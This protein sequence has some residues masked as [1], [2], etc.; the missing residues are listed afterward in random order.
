[1]SCDA[2]RTLPPVISQGYT[3]KGTYKEVAGLNTC[4][5][6]T[7]AQEQ[8]QAL[9]FS[10]CYWSAKCFHWACGPLRHFRHGHPD[11]AGGRPS[12]YKIELIGSG[13]RFLRRE[14]CPARMVPGGHR[15]EEKRSYELRL[16]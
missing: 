13:A 14:L 1:M 4:K 11:P 6:H 7:D 9:T 3:T 5:S 16:Q 12:S 2:C 10:R 15:R 8:E